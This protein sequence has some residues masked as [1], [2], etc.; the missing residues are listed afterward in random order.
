MNQPSVRVSEGLIKNGTEVIINHRGGLTN[1]K[2][3]GYIAHT[4]AYLCDM[5]RQLQAFKAEDVMRRVPRF[6]S[7]EEADAW[8]EGR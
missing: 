7:V 1:G 6:D 2:V 4:D 5:G 3:V 8:L